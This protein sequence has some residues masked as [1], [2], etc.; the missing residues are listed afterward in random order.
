MPHKSLSVQD[1]ADIVTSTMN[2]EQLEEFN[3]NKDLNYAVQS[4]SNTRYRV[5]AYHDQGRVGLV[6]RRINQVIPTVEVMSLPP[7]LHLI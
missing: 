3:K 7:V 5:N 2:D 1:T 6:L 4:R